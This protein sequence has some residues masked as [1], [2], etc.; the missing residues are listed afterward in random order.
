M[1]KGEH[2]SFFIFASV[3]TSVA[4]FIIAFGPGNNLVRWIKAGFEISR[5]ERQ[6][7]EYQTQIDR[8][9]HRIKMLRSDRDSLEKFAREQFH[10]TEAGDD[11]Y[12]ISE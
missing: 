12:L 6:I 9:D 4:F 5:Q 10:F 11:V 8:M 1:F 7:I 2:R 3:V